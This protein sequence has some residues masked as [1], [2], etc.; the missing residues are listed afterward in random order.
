MYTLGPRAVG[1]VLDDAGGLA[2]AD[3]EGVHE[4]LFGEAMELAGGGGGGEARG[5][6][7][8]MEVTRVER[9]RHREADPAHHLDG[10]DH[11]FEHGAPPRARRLADGERGR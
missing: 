3:A 8:G 6:R 9:A 7:G 5:D 10:G 11:G 2:A 1:E 4:L